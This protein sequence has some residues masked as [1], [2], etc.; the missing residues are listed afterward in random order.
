MQRAT[1]VLMDNAAKIRATL[2]VVPDN[3]GS[4][5]PRPSPQKVGEAAR[6]LNE[7]GFQVLRESRFGVDVLGSADQYLKHLNVHIPSSEGPFVAPVQE[8]A[9]TLRNLVDSVEVVPPVKL[10]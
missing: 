5:V 8:P 1:L 10:L 6:Q 3:T 7:L 2:R 4:V 9:K